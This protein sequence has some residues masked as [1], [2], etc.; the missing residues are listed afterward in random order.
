MKNIIALIIIL[1]LPITAAVSKE[2]PE[3]PFVYVGGYAE[4][5][6]PPDTATLTFTV[7]VQDAK[8]EAALET[9]YKRG[10]ELIALFRKM[11]I[12]KNDFETYNIDKQ[13]RKDDEDQK[14]VGYEVTQRFKVKLHGL[15]HYIPLFENLLK[16]NN[17]VNIN[18]DFDVEKRK[19]VEADLIAE[20]CA[21]AKT[22]AEN[23]V[24]GLGVKLGPVFGV[25]DRG[26][27]DFGF[28]GEGLDKLFHK[29]MMGEASGSSQI[30]F[31]PSTITIRKSVNA[32]YKME[33]QS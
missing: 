11:E 28:G 19:E 8:P 14:I 4:K 24:K 25:S 29:S 12:P 33:T 31:A 27:N 15:A 18:A 16:M 1:L 21:D 3:F 22:H 13:Y 2:L 30:I 32:I 20:A 17:L 6:V 23:M 9:V 10:L 7:E 5:E 26:I